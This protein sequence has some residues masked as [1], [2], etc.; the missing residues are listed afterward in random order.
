[1]NIL[2]RSWDFPASLF[3]DKLNLSLIFLQ[4]PLIET[5]TE[6]HLIIGPEGG[7]TDAEENLLQKAGTNAI[8]LG[9][10]I[11]RAETAALV[12]LTALQMKWGDI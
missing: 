6:I 3:F 2:K 11:L 5:N 9:S 10:R 7:F 1:V 12:G 8:T 4:V